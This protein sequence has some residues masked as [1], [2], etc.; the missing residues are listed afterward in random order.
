MIK[1]NKS[2]E[3]NKKENQKGSATL[4]VIITMFSFF[5]ILMGG[6]IVVSNL[7]KS[8]LNSTI[9]IKQIYEEDVTNIDEKYNEINMAVAKDLPKTDLTKPYLPNSTFSKVEGT[10]LSNGLVIQDNIGNQ[11]V[12][13]EVPKNIYSTA[14][15]SEEYSNIEKDMQSYANE[16]RLAGY[17]DQWYEGCGIET[18]I[19]YNTLKNKM[20]KSVYEN[21]GFWIGRYEVGTEILRTKLEDELAQIRVTKDLY[22]YNF[23][24]C[25]I[26]QKR[27]KTMGTVNS[28]SSLMFGIQWDLMLKHIETKNSKTKDEL[29]AYSS[30][31]GN[32][33][34]ISF[35]IS[36][37]KAKYSNNSSA[38]FN[39]ISGIYTKPINTSV[40]LTTGA[41]QRNQTMNIYDLAGNQSEWTLE[42]SNDNDNPSTYRGGDYTN[43]GTTYSA[44]SR[45]LNNININNSSIGFRISIYN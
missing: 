11:Y 19:E 7:I 30:S 45:I 29:R 12:W 17:T 15:N 41:T 42:K 13:I 6:Y 8:Q 24:T 3:N 5:T 4:L 33:N 39:N 31:W 21:G 40:L 37:L 14:K 1:I 16:Y 18:D 22:P 25:E 34:N 32:Y 9:K 2:K 35:D 28:T 26:A 20:L 23:V 10:D 44:V 43:N 38:S 36:N 27:A